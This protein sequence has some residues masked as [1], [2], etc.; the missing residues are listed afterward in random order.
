MFSAAAKW[1]SD[2]LASPNVTL[3]AEWLLGSSRAGGPVKASEKSMRVDSSTITAAFSAESLSFSISTAVPIL[4][5]VGEKS[6]SN[7]S[8]KTLE[9]RIGVT[10]VVEVNSRSIKRGGGRGGTI[11]AVEGS[12]FEEDEEFEEEEEG[13]AA[14]EAEAGAG[15]RAR[16]GAGTVEFEG[17]GF[18]A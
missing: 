6:R 3:D 16:A 5:E 4:G 13:R 18:C 7:K 9:F 10:G 1:S 12:E 8:A 2:W 15:A 11:A 14:E 17:D